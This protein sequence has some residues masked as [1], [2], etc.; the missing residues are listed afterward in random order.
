MSVKAVRWKGWGLW[1][2]GFKENVSFIS[3]V[4]NFA[5]HSVNLNDASLRGWGIKR[6]TAQR[7][8]MTTFRDSA[9]QPS[10]RN[11]GVA[12]T[13][14]HYE[15]DVERSEV[16]FTQGEVLWYWR[17][18]HSW[19]ITVH[20]YNYQHLRLFTGKMFLLLSGYCWTVVTKRILYRRYSSQSC[21]IC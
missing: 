9:I 2:E 8:G 5:P 4:T 3:F 17:V 20:C 18:Q 13:R 12:G 16:V 14:D 6:V 10:N 11:D 1:R 21:I 15:C 19:H 7:I